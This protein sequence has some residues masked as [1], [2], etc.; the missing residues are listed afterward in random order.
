MNDQ[1]GP[2]AASKERFRIA[3]D[4]LLDGL[5]EYVEEPGGG[6][7]D[8]SLFGQEFNGGTWAIAKMNMVLHGVNNADLANDDTL[9]TPKHEEPN[10][11]LTRFNRVLTNPPFSQHYHSDGMRHRERFEFGWAPETGK[12]ADLIFAQ[13]VLAILADDGLGAIVMPHG[14]LFRGGKERDI[15][16]KIIEADRLDAV[17]G[18]APNLFVNTGIPAC[19]LVLR[20]PGPRPANRK[21]R[22]LFVSADREFTAGRAQN[23]LDEK[24]IERGAHRAGD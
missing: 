2:S 5:Q 17:I 15:R 18:L 9:A 22:V 24:H 1:L 3:L 7:R 14:V 16:K 23:F 4:C 12:K 19:V 20:G 13:Q 11:E 10:G 6:K 8:L 21:G